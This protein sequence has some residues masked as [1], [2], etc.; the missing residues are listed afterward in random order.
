MVTFWKHGEGSG[1]PR[2]SL[3]WGRKSSL[4]GL[5][6]GFLRFQD[7]CL[8]WGKT[9]PA[10]HINQRH[11][12]WP[13]PCRKTSTMWYPCL[14]GQTIQIAFILLFVNCVAMQVRWEQFSRVKRYSLLPIMWSSAQFTVL[15][16]VRGSLIQSEHP[17]SSVSPKQAV[18][19]GKVPRAFL[20]TDLL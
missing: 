5:S 20:D 10:F 8:N 16:W 15:H 17:H 18:P 1:C 3:N 11:S 7:V 13:H 19:F 2:F 12:W 14:V 6:L 4:M 9:E